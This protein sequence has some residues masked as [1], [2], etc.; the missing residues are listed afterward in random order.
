M[1]TR[2]VLSGLIISAALVTSAPS[3]SFAAPINELSGNVT[4]TSSYIWRG[5]SQTTGTALQGGIEASMGDGVYAGAWMSNV[6]SFDLDIN[7]PAGTATGSAHSGSEVDI[8]GGYQ[9]KADVFNYDAGAILYFYPNEP[10]GADLN[11]VELYV[12]VSRDFYGAK[13][14]ISSDAGV[15]LEGYAS[16]PLEHWNLDLHIG[17][18]SVEEDYDGYPFNPMDDY[19]DFKIAVSKDVGG[20]GL[21]FALTDTNLSGSAGDFRT[22]VTVSKDFTP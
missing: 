19:F 8:Y 5:L 10:A 12:D 4:A 13:V 22:A 16:M 3:I 17:R 2:N 7:I 9:G 18:Y 20:F 21:E 15:Y 14:S 1:N 6:D 11:F